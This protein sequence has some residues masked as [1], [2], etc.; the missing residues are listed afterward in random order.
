MSRRRKRTTGGPM[1]PLDNIR[2]EAR[3]YQ[4]VCYGRMA[5]I[6]F[7]HVCKKLGIDSE[8]A[9]SGS[10]SPLEYVELARRYPWGTA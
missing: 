4:A 8:A 2:P 10:S 3:M 6:L 1:E 9:R 5:D 7:E